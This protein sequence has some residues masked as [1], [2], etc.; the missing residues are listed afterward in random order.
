MGP[1]F[2]FFFC[3]NRFG[4]GLLHNCKSLFNFWRRIREDIC[5]RKS[6]PRYQGYGEEIWFECVF[7]CLDFC[8]CSVPLVFFLAPLLIRFYAL[9]S[10]VLFPLTPVAVLNQYS[11][12][13]TSVVCSVYTFFSLSLFWDPAFVFWFYTFGV[14]L[15]CTTS[16]VISSDPSQ[17]CLNSK[18]NQLLESCYSPRG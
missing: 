8:L 6:I 7:F 2:Q 5:N 16:S 10:V 4:I 14:L 9:N 3:L 12:I 18:I 15:F 13:L 17:F 1:I 11:S